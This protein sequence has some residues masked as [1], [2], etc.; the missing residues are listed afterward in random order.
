VDLSLINE[1]E[2]KNSS[3]NIHELNIDLHIN[4][5]TNTIDN[6]NNNNKINNHNHPK[7]S[8]ETPVV[9]LPPKKLSILKSHSRKKLV[10]KPISIIQPIETRASELENVSI[11]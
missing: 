4:I 8:I 5:N 9:S 6:N 1:G 7:L 10:L 2:N 11:I 3:S